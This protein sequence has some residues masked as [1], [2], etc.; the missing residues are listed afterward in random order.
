M[1]DAPQVP[2]NPISLYGLKKASD[3]IAALAK[4]VGSETIVLGGH[5]WGGSVVWRAAIWYPELVT[6]VFSIC[7]PY[8][9]P[10]N[11]FVSTEDLVKGPLP[12]FAYQLHLASGELEKSIKDEQALKQFLRGVYGARGPKGELAFDPEKGIIVENLPKMGESRILAGK[13]LDYYVKEYSKH[14]IH[15]TLNW[16]RQHRTN[17]EEDQA[18]IDKKIINQPALFIQAA[19]D[20]VLKPDMAK[21]MDIFIPNLTRSEVA[22]TH[23]ALIQKPEEVNKII[24]Q[25]LEGQGLVS[26]SKSSL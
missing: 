10:H 24:G 25:W 8:I 15:S 22:A 16:Y 17:W 7:T 19:Y 20:S 4:E 23:W 14:G 9:P 21:D 13:V 2:P 5:D 26:I 12:Q 11:K 1:Q 6:H 3:G 18:L